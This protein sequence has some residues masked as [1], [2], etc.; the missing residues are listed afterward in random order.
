[1][2]GIAIEDD[3]LRIYWWFEGFG[4]AAMGLGIGWWRCVGMG[5]TVMSSDFRDFGDRGRGRVC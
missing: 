5:L 4:D 2:L 1:M 3:G